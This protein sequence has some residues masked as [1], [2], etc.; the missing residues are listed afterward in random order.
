[1]I[2]RR[3]GTYFSKAH[4]AFSAECTKQLALVRPAEPLS[5]NLLALVEIVA[6]KPKTGKLSEPRGDCDNWAKIPLDAAT[7]V[8]I[9][10]DD[11]QVVAMSCMKRYAEP[12]EL[13]GANLWI[14]AEAS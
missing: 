3:G 4:E 8:G 12:G 6:A 9:W 7:K 10:N 1:M 5:G 14:G 13:P 11:M 2:N